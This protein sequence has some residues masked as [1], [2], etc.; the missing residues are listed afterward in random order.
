MANCTGVQSSQGT[1]QAATG[2]AAAKLALG[3]FMLNGLAQCAVK[4]CQSGNCT[5]GITANQF[6]ALEW[7]DPLQVG[8]EVRVSVSGNGI[9]FCQ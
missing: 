4:T 2:L 8:N 5:F 3:H 7:S 9:C 1:G 6:Q